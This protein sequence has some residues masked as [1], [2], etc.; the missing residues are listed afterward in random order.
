[1]SEFL[2]KPAKVHTPIEF[3]TPLTPD[4]QK[5]SLEFFRV[6]NFLLQFAPTDPSETALV[7][8]VATIGIGAGKPFDPDVL[9]PQMRGAFEQGMRDAWA[10]IAASVAPSRAASAAPAITDV[11]IIG[12]GFAGVTAARELSMRGR[13][14]V[15]L[16]AR[17]RLG[18]RTHT[19]EHDGHA[20]ELGGT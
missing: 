10:L 11:A 18:G 4:E 5:T 19:M 15:L 16:E 7:A 9:T 6:L 17:D 1:L 20:L 14:S 3:A 12:G 2:G 13:S 8:R